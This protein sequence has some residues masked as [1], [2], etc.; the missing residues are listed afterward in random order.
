M[1]ACCEQNL[2]NRHS[3]ENITLDTGFGRTIGDHVQMGVTM[4]ILA[5]FG[6]KGTHVALEQ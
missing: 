6:D 1:F 5:I 3:V 4:N 2:E